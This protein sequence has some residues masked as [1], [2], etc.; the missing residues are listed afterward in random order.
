MRRKVA[1]FLC[2][3]LGCV[4]VFAGE[5]QVLENRAKEYTDNTKALKIRLPN[6]MEALLLSNEGLK[7]TSVALS[8]DTGAW[9]DPIEHQGMAHFVE[10]LLFLGTKAYPEEKE[11]DE[12]M[13]QRGGAS[14]AYTEVSKTVFGFS[15]GKEHLEGALDRFSSF[16]HRSFVYRL[17]DR[18][19]KACHKS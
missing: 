12:Y 2:F 6:G 5:Y 4:G 11:Y 13:H 3:V 1:V 16:F 17:Y 8:V 9:D 10:H 19:G 7:E 15:I 14:N 18:K